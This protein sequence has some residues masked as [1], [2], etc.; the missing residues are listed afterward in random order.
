[1]LFAFRNSTILGGGS[2]QRSWFLEIAYLVKQYPLINHHFGSNGL[3]DKP[4]FRG[5]A[6]HLLQQFRC[7]TLHCRARQRP[8]PR[9][10]ANSQLCRR[11]ISCQI[12]RALVVLPPVSSA[13]ASP[14]ARSPQARCENMWQQPWVTRFRNSR[15]GRVRV[16][17]SVASPRRVHDRGDAHFGEFHVFVFGKAKANHRRSNT[18]NP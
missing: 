8:R 14:D 6:S 7:K 3:N 15:C 12:I 11:G 9:R 2:Y 18:A 16:K 10:H 1:M 5:P 13:P 4:A 17:A